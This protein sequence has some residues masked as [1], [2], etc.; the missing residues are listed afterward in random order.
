MRVDNT[1]YGSVTM[2]TLP[3]KETYN[4]LPVW[5]WTCL[6]TGG[7]KGCTGGLMHTLHWLSLEDLLSC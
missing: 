6:R 1:L 3:Y 5:H 7:C 4:I 2:V